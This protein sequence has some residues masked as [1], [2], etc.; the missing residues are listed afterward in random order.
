MLLAD[1]RGGEGMTQIPKWLL[2]KE[3][4][5]ARQWKA[6]KRRELKEA[7]RAFDVYFIGCAFTPAKDGQDGR[8]KDAF[9]SLK[10]VLSVKNWGR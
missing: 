3:G 7:I 5:T 4:I 10:Q 9:K 2:E 8:I 1:Q 6:R